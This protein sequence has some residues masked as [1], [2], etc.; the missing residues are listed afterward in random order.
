M[1]ADDLDNLIA[2]SLAGVQSALEGD[3]KAAPA[4]TST[5][6]AATSAGEAVRELQQGPAR[7]EADGI[8]SE[9]FFSNLVKSFQDEQFQKSMA[10]ALK[11]SD[12]KETVTDLAASTA[13]AAASSSDAGAEDF[14]KNF[15]KSFENAVGNDESF[16]NQMTSLVTSMLSKDVIVEPLQQIADALEPWLRDQT[17]LSSSDRTRYESQLKIYKDIVKVYKSAGDADP[18]PDSVQVEVQR[19]LTELHLLGEPPAEVMKQ[20][21]PKESENGD[22]SFEDFVKSMGL[23]SNL[24]AAEQDL[25]KKLTEDPEELTK[26]MKD[27][28]GK[29][30]GENPE[31]ACKQ[32]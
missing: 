6:A 14:L 2:D 5:E 7:S 31:E 29:L 11:I 16:Q 9:V 28:A 22:E 12:E 25:L 3:R 32:Q 24:G 23:D 13:P 27:M 26:V 17:N 21:A 15:M 8:A 1:E 30:D 10:D 20:I 19:L 4:Q 18:V